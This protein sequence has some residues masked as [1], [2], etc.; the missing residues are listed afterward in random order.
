[1]ALARHFAGPGVKLTIVARRLAELDTLAAELRGKGAEVFVQTADM[2]DPEQMTAWV[3]AAEAALGPIDTC[4]INA[5]I[6]IVSEA[7]AVSNADAERL[8]AINIIAP[9]RIARLVGPAMKARGDGTLVVVASLAAMS[10]VPGMADYS[11]SKAA[12]SAWFET[13]RMELKS[14]GVHVLTVYPGPVR[15]AME[16]AAWEKLDATGCQKRLPVGTPEEL[17]RLVET[18]IQKK[19]ARVIYPAVYSVSHH[20]RSVSQW[21]T[22][23][24]APKPTKD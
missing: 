24:F 15:T 4:I 8:L 16:A 1:M 14:S 21:V 18:A 10:M 2:A 23:R 11:A 5:G 17:A 9:Q 20:L 7:L 13:L 3:V 22:E 19:K 6:Q 12:V